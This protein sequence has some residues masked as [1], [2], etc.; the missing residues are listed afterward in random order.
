MK[1]TKF[2]LAVA[3]VSL[4]TSA[5]LH[6]ADPAVT[7][8]VAMDG[9][10][11]AAGTEAAPFAT[12]TNALAK[13]T[14]GDTINLKAGTYELKTSP[15]WKGHDAAYQ[16]SNNS[17][18]FLL[19]NAVSVIGV[20]G[21]DK[22]FID[23]KSSGNKYA[24][25]LNNAN[26]LV[27]GI[28]VKNVSSYISYQLRES[29]TFN[30]VKGRV[31]DCIV[32]NCSFYYVGAYCLKSS[33]AHLLNCVSDK[34]SCS[35][36][37]SLSAGILCY[38][39]GIH[40]TVTNCVVRN[41]SAK[42]GPG[43]L[44]D[45]SSA[46][47]IYGCVFT[48][49][50]STIGSRGGSAPVRLTTGARMENCVISNNT[51]NTFSSWIGGGGLRM[52]GAGTVVRNCLIVDNT[53]NTNG[54][55]GGVYIE[56]GLLEN[57]TI[58]GNKVTS[59]HGHGVYQ[60]GGTIRNCII[61]NNNADKSAF[62]SENHYR[63]SGTVEYTCTYPEME[64][65]GNLVEEPYLT[66]IA[67][68]D[69][70]LSD[71]S[72]LYDMG[73]DQT[74]MTTTLK[75]DLLGNA[76]ILGK[77]VDL[78]CYEK[79]EPAVK[80][81]SLSIAPDV[82]KGASP[83]TVRFTS[84]LKHTEGAVSYK[85]NFGDG[86]SSTESN[87]TKVYSKSGKYAVS[88]T[89]V[90]GTRE[91]TAEMTSPIV[92]GTSV[93]Y[94]NESGSATWPYDTAA[95]GTSSVDDALVD[96]FA[97]TSGG[98]A[99]LH[100]GAGTFNPK[101]R[102]LIRD[103]PMT[104]IG[105]NGAKLSGAALT[106]NRFG[107]V[108]V[109]DDDSVVSNLVITGVNCQSGDQVSR[110]GALTISKGL[111]AD[112]TIDSPYTSSYTMSAVYMTGGRIERLFVYNTGNGDSGH[113]G[114]GC[115]GVYMTGGTISD[116]VFSNCAATCVGAVRCHGGIVT[117]SLFYGCR[118]GQ[119]NNGN[120]TAGWAQ[121]TG[122]GMIVNS[123]F[124]KCAYTTS[125][126]GSRPA[127]VSL[128]AGTPTLRGCLVVKGYSPSSAAVNVAYGTAESCT[129]AD[130][131][132]TAANSGTAAGVSYGGGTLLNTIVYGNTAQDGSA[133]DLSGGG[134][135][136]HCLVGV[137]PRFRNSPA[138]DYRI[139]TE[140]PAVNQALFRDWMTGA[141]DLSGIR[142]KIGSAPDIGCYENHLQGFFLMVE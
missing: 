24:F 116:S 128:T 78:G 28:T 33:N 131:Y 112:V 64:G 8:W 63:T 48:K 129:I 19:T 82:Y 26:A 120:G 55:G 38:G 58:V 72:D 68:G 91:K 98:N 65:T 59:G 109:A 92:C 4:F 39:N 50:T 104:V 9:D 51:V 100:I 123:R 110:G 118:A 44:C 40:P 46:P 30:V 1:H 97:P 15:I 2:F 42:Q 31:E 113:G 25:Y 14:N 127:A 101:A 115:G 10:D 94:V 21:A 7:W 79:E 132:Q 89:I 57:C 45:G 61:A 11:A 53:E 107:V 27:K 108:E 124:V 34:T 93:A 102:I 105:A 106:D 29:A 125:V 142:R 122:S 22:T 84:S 62:D 13:A 66:D 119:T 35:D 117:N 138:G 99:V 80:P 86:T 36:G 23:G 141:T 103:I 56:G 52:S 130:N 3:A 95:K 60:S 47:Y 135:P 54:G 85:W 134:E 87:P 49:C 74:W 83:F 17:P 16:S 88:L 111:A 137:D 139:L 136:D 6:A 90:N 73:S 70:R 140:S 41:S 81:I 77:A 5:L 133:V 126:N 121:I 76:R 32:T 71:M 114:G 12:L 18:M 69:C 20:E 67:N 96:L 43:L 37:L 75:V